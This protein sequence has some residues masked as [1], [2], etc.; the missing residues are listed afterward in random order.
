MD[1]ANNKHV[2]TNY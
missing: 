1:L 2:I